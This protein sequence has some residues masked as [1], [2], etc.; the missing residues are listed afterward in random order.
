MGVRNGPGAG[1]GFLT[2]GT[3][4]NNGTGTNGGNHLKMEEL[5][6]LLLDQAMMEEAAVLAAAVVVGT[7]S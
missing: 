1:G 6:A 5:E 4:S 3:N 2:D 7:M